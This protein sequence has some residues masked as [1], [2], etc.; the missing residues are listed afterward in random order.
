MIKWTCRKDGSGN[1]VSECRL[2]KVE[3]KRV[4]RPCKTWK[5]D[6]AKT[7]E[8]WGLTSEMAK[9]REVW[10]NRIFYENVKP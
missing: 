1:M 7:T 10:R 3:G 9:D 4:G 5:E 2:G 6:V 8:K